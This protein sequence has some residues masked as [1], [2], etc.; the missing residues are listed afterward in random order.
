MGETAY[1]AA[2]DRC[3]RS[4]RHYICRLKP[5]FKEGIIFKKFESKKKQ[6]W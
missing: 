4:S 5:D 1:A 3:W 6:K 2:A